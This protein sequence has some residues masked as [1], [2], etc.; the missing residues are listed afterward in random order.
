MGGKRLKFPARGKYVDSSK[1]QVF[2]D[3]DDKDDKSVSEEEHEKRVR[4]LR[5]LGLLK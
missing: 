1:E 4:M 5:D 3:D 2:R